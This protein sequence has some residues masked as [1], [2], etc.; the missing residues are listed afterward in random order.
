MV[1]NEQK[2]Q[3]LQENLNNSAKNQYFFH[4]IQGQNPLSIFP[5]AISKRKI[6]NFFLKIGN[7]LIE[8]LKIWFF[9]FFVFISQFSQFF[10]KKYHFF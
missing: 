4:A 7:I 9:I 1:K 2:S 8:S 3:F 6:P 10:N 5:Q